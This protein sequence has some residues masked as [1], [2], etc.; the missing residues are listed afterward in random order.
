MMKEK[1]N[2]IIEKGHSYLNSINQYEEQNLLKLCSDDVT[3]DSDITEFLGDER[4]DIRNF[5]LYRIDEIVFSK[6]EGPRR[7]AMENVLS[8]F[9]NYQ[10]VNLIYMILGDKN[11]VTMQTPLSL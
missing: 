4:L 11:K 1:I 10:D 2:Q 6:K 3:I 7:E 9:R 8:S 5:F